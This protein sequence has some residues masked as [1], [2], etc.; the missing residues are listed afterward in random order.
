MKCP[1]KT[2]NMTYILPRNTSGKLFYCSFV[3]LSIMYVFYQPYLLAHIVAYQSC[4]HGQGKSMK[5]A[6]KLT[7]NCCFPL[8][9]VCVRSTIKYG[10]VI[11]WH[12][13]KPTNAANRKLAVLCSVWFLKR[14]TLDL[15][16]KVWVRS[17]SN[18]GLVSIGAHWSLLKM[19]A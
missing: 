10:L 16:F 5:L 2:E 3:L 12:T 13:L 19:L 11:H 14:S 4:W 15:L 18:L 7:I 17:P 6:C 8:Y 9:K 1:N